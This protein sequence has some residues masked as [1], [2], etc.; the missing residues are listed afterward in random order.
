[1]VPAGHHV[2]N[3]ANIFNAQG[4]SHFENEVDRL[5]ADRQFLLSR[6]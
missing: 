1:L 6:F 3:R 4:T 2:V 5:N